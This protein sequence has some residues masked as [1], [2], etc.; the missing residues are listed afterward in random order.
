M[1]QE[2]KFK[3]CPNCGAAIPEMASFCP[4][5]ATSVNHQVELKMPNLFWGR[6]LRVLVVVLIAAGV[7]AGFYFYNRPQIVEGVGEVLYQDDEGEY[8]LVLG[9]PENRFEPVKEN[10]QSVELG[11]EYRFPTRL[12]ISFVGS[13]ANVGQAFLQKTDHVTVEFLQPEDAPS[14]ITCTEPEPTDYDPEA[15]LVSYV[16]FI[17]HDET[18]D[19]QWTLYMK[20]GDEIRLRQT[21]IMTTIQTY[22]YYPEDVPMNT[23]EELQTL[24]DQIAEEVEPD[25]VVNLHL[26][27]VTYEG[28]LVMEK[29]P[30]SLYGSEENGQRTTF[31][32]TTQVKAQGSWISYF[33]NIDFFGNG[34]GVGISASARLHL[35][36]CGVRGWKTGVLGYGTAWVNIRYSLVEDNEIGFHF[37]SEGSSASHTQYTGNTFRNNQTGILLERVPTEVSISFDECLFT[38]NGTDIDNQCDHTIDISGATFE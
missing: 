32:G 3:K 33:E 30:V 28:G 26:P 27:A 7:L 18:C 35:T 12:Y 34:Q 37:N 13:G 25:A 29:R 23:I 16:D 8:Q 31:T 24:V 21:V 15:A 17:G 2:M 4:A 1:D 14:P 20:N 22:D 10:Y 11:G 38:E 9:W 6:A 5:C 19:L 36:N